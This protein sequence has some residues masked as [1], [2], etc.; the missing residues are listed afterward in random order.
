MSTLQLLLA[1]LCN[2]LLPNLGRYRCDCEVG[3]ELCEITGTA[4]ELE[5]DSDVLAPQYVPFGQ[6]V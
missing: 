5:A 6:S 3:G 4:C 2:S 1:K